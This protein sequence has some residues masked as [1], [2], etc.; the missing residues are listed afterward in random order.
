MTHLSRI[1]FSFERSNWIAFCIPTSELHNQPLEEDII[2]MEFQRTPG[3]L[4]IMDAV[5][6]FS[7]E[8]ANMGKDV[9][10]HPSTAKEIF[11]RQLITAY[12]NFGFCCRFGSHNM[13]LFQD[14]ESP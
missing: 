4:D 13:R 2:Y 11:V 9:R 6:S 5:R 10:F 14:K 8:Q 12:S 7:R 1:S 3:P